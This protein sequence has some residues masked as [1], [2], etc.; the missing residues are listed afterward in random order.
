M[1][2]DKVDSSF[3]QF[4]RLRKQASDEFVNGN[5]EALEGI[6]THRSPATIFGPKGD[7]VQG[8]EQVNS[9]NA[10]GAKMFEPE[11]T[12]AFEIMHR[13]A[14]GDLAY[15]VGIQRS[16]V[17]MKGKDAPIPMD[18]RITEIFRREDGEWKLVHRHADKLSAQ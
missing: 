9:A 16:V 5:F 10:S 13:G 15:W 14:D 7:C 4:L 6:S 2:D 3:E 18:L 1:N 11:G 12:N 17:R 8:A